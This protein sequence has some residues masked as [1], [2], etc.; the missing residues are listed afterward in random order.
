MDTEKNWLF[1]LELIIRDAFVAKTSGQCFKFVYLSYFF[2]LANAFLTV[3][4]ISWLYETSSPFKSLML[5]IR[6]VEDESHP[7][8]FKAKQDVLP[9][10][11]KQFASHISF[12]LFSIFWFNFFCLPE[13]GQSGQTP[14]CNYIST[15]H[16]LTA[17]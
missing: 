3:A 13:S 10:R 8:C 11:D 2:I 16:L 17:L 14:S 15:L 4:T 1:T 5:I 7:Q 6:E 9:L 12:N